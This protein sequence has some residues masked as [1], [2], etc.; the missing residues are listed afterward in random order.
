MR[1]IKFLADLIS[2][3]DVPELMAAGAGILCG[4]GHNVARGRA[5]IIGCRCWNLARASVI[6][7]PEDVLELM[8]AGA[9]ISHV[10]QA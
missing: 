10:R 6:M 9:G 5:G 1:H 4:V 8:A 3:E 7:L 2:P